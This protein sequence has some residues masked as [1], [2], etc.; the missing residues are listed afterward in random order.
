MQEFGTLFYYTPQEG[1]K[2]NLLNINLIQ[3]K[4]GISID[5]IDHITK[6]II[7]EYWVTNKKDNVKF[8]QSPFP[9]DASF[10][11]TLFV[12]TTL[13]GEELKQIEESHGGYLN[14]WVGG[15]MHI[16]V[17]TFYYM[18][19]WVPERTCFP[20][21]QTWHGISHAPSI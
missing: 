17:K 3:S 5:Q 11:K 19:A 4:Y 6:K 13:I 10:E 1:P 21:Y 16:N 18:A 15:L 2:L 14:H 12:T 7:Q 20:C 8:Q 9:V